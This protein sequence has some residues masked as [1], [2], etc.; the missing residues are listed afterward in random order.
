MITNNRLTKL[1]EGFIVLTS[2]ADEKSVYETLHSAIFGKIKKI[3]GNGEQQTVKNIQKLVEVEYD[4][5]K[6]ALNNSFPLKDRELTEPKL[7]WV[8]V[9]LTVFKGD[10]AKVKRLIANGVTRQKIYYCNAKFTTLSEKIKPDKE[11]IIKYQKIIHTYEQM[12]QQGKG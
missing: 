12:V 3:N 8:I 11:I 2:I 1:I 9:V 4:L 5:P 7:M 6:G 10:R